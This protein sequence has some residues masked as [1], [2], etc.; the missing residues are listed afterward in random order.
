VRGRFDG[1]GTPQA[2]LVLGNRPPLLL[3]EGAQ[4]ASVRDVEKRMQGFVFPRLVDGPERP[5][6]SRVRDW[7]GFA[8]IYLRASVVVEAESL[9]KSPA[10]LYLSGHGIECAL[11]AC[12]VAAGEMPRRT[13]DLIGLMERAEATGYRSS[14]Q[15]LWRIVRLNWYTFA[16]PETDA[17]LKARYPLNRRQSDPMTPPDAIECAEVGCELFAQAFRRIG[18]GFDAEAWLVEMMQLYSG[19]APQ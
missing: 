5:F 7:I 16:D 11:K 14:E 12:I 18:M 17:R 10:S 6:E 9:C 19:Q 8:Q 13:H 15:N 3:F 1:A 4:M 2:M